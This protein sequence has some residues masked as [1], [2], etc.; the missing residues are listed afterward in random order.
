MA[1][2]PREALPF[3]L[4]ENRLESAGEQCSQVPQVARDSSKNRQVRWI[5]KLAGSVSEKFSAR[6]LGGMWTQQDDLHLVDAHARRFENPSH[7]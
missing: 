6:E 2:P 1:P 5:G 7:S 3:N 4:T